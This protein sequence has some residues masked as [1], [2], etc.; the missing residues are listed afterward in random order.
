[1]PFVAGYTI[2]LFFFFD[3]LS[4]F[5]RFLLC[6]T[7][8]YLCNNRFVYSLCPHQA[9]HLL[10]FSLNIHTFLLFPLLLVSGSV[11]AGIMLPA[12]CLTLYHK[13][14]RFLTFFD[15]KIFFK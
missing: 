2:N 10:A 13:P 4:Y 5:Y 15:K 11:P 12:S 6:N 8:Q 9:Y 14:L 3:A 1:M 7:C